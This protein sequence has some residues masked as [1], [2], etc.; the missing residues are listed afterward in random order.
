[1]Y[2]I[3]FPIVYLQTAWVSLHPSAGLAENIVVTTACFLSIL[4]TAHFSY[5]YYETPVRR[6][7][8]LY[9]VLTERLRVDTS[10]EME[11]TEH[12]HRRSTW[13]CANAA[14]SQRGYAIWPLIGWFSALRGRYSCIYG[15]N[16]QNRHVRW[17]WNLSSGNHYANTM[18]VCGQPTIWT[19][20]IET[21]SIRKW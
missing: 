7:M 18:T 6:R 2:L 3:H 16:R 1:M 12:E 9:V 4:M 5:K 17:S 20:C 11:D 15:W 14:R 13:I 8:V 10:A 21:T 19:R